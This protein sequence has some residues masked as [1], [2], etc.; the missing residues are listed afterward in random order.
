MVGLVDCNNFFVSCERSV[1]PNLD[2]LPVVVLSNN[3][4]CVVARS[5]ESKAMGIKMGQ[6]AFEIR[7]LI[8]SGRLIAYSGNHLLYRSK[9]LRVHEIFREYAPSTIDYSVDEAFLDVAGIPVS[10]LA[11]IGEAI[12][13]RCWD[14]ER[15]PVTLG[16]APTKTLSK[17]AT[18]YG[19]KHGQ[20]VVVMPKVEEFLEIMNQ[21][22]ISGLWGIGRR[23]TKKLYLMGVFTIGD[24][25]RKELSWV[26]SRMGVNG[27]RSWRELHGEPCIELAHVQRVIQDS[28]SE[29]RTFPT[30]INDIDWLRSRIAIYCADVG[31]RLRAMNGECGRL[32]LFLH[33][34]RF[35]PERGWYAPEI[36]VD[37]NPRLSDS[38]SLTVAALRCL[39]EVYDRSV[40]YK[41]GGVIL[42]DIK[43]AENIAP[44]LFEDIEEI[45]EKREKSKRLMN[46]ID[47][48]NDG[49]GP[50]K[51]R[52]AIQIPKGSVGRNDGYSSS[53]GAPKE[54]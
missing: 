16:F 37:F 24:F 4:G 15:I 36:S 46:V 5:N 50:Q 14:E 42:S 13:T 10:A 8:Q 20:R 41:R 34:N 31:R 17:I 28:I 3:D 21:T 1:D 38:Q 35:H 32:T 45:R 48:L 25:Y 22:E 53:F 26:R 7:D 33:T 2:G 19:K 23:L 11:G 54:V 27:E 6:P 12:W 30:D 43:P 18:E 51:I 29:T 44:S 47:G 40:A 39:E 52:L 9:S 49:V